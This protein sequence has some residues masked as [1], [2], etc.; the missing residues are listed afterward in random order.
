MST[1]GKPAERVILTE[2]NDALEEQIWSGI[3]NSA[4]ALLSYNKKKSTAAFDNVWH[5]CLLFKMFQAKIL[6]ALVRL[7]ASYP[8]NRKL[9]IKLKGIRSLER[10]ITILQ[11]FRERLT[12]DARNKKSTIR[13][14]QHYHDYFLNPHAARRVQNARDAL[15]TLYSLG[16]NTS[17]SST[18]VHVKENRRTSGEM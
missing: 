5:I 1:I 14:R 16:Y 10:N 12:E 11:H 3:S 13:R 9:K 7:I 2:L 6:S 8:K 15:E 4:F 18:G 17:T